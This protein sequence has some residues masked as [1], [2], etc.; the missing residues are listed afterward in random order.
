MSATK[1]SQQPSESHSS[2]DVSTSP[3]EV[4]K[5][6]LDDVSKLTD[7]LMEVDTAASEPPDDM[8]ALV[9]RLRVASRRADAAILAFG[10]LAKPS[11]RKRIRRRLRRL[12]TG[13]GALRAAQVHLQTLDDLRQN[14]PA[15]LADALDI[16]VLLCERDVQMEWRNLKACMAS[17]EMT[18]PRKA[19][20]QFVRSWK[21]RSAKAQEQPTWSSFLGNGLAPAMEVVRELV[22][23]TPSS[24]DDLHALR[25]GGKKL[26]YALEIFGPCL[27]EAQV[28][29]LAT[30]LKD[31]QVR[32]GS[33]NDLA[34]LAE[35][36]GEYAQTGRKQSLQM[37]S[38]RRRD[39]QTGNGETTD[40]RLP[41]RLEA[42]QSWINQRLR[43][44]VEEFTAAWPSASQS[45]LDAFAVL[46]ERIQVPDDDQHQATVPS[47]GALS[48]SSDAPD[49]V[50]SN[51]MMEVNAQVAGR[52]RTWGPAALRSVAQS[53]QDPQCDRLA[54]LDIGTNSIRL[55]IA[56]VRPDGSYRVLDD[57]KDTTRLGSGLVT[58]G[59]LSPAA[60]D[61]AIE[62]V[63]RMNAI[64]QGYG[65]K[66]LR[67]VGTCAVREAENSKEFVKRMK[68]EAG[69]ELEVISAEAEAR[70]AHLSVSTAFDLNA[71][72]AAVVDIGGGSTEIVLSSRGVIEH[73]YS[74]MLGAVGLTEEHKLATDDGDGIPEKRFRQMR[75]QVRDA[76]KRLIGKPPLAPQTVFGTGGTFTA[77]ASVALCR[78]RPVD[79]DP[80]ALNV[81]GYD[82][83]RPT[84]KHLLHWLRG[85]SS[86][87]RASVNG[88]SPERAEIIVAGA[89]IV[90]AVLG[91]LGSNAVRVHDRGIRD[92][93]MLQMIKEHGPARSPGSPAPE[94]IDP[95]RSFAR[96]CNYEVAHSEHVTMLALEVFDQLAEAQGAAW[97]TPTARRLLEAASVLHDVGYYINYAKH[98]KHSYH[99]ILHSELAGFT[100][101]EIAI[102]A[103]VARYHRRS[104][105]K[106]SHA[107]FSTLAK[108]DQALVRRLAGILRIVD[109]LDRAHGQNV[110]R[111][112]VAVRGAEVRFTA[113]AKFEPA[114]DIW[115]AQRKSKL[116]EST[117]DRKVR[118]NWVRVLSEQSNRVTSMEEHALAG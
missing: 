94:A 1:A 33:V 39:N 20:K 9:H 82:L 29:P 12:R 35:R 80:G 26:R 77:L 55:V 57:E 41:A 108:K 51:R 52:D 67:A 7:R 31:L 47:N 28:E 44:A 19:I 11:R 99:L 25:I 36:L 101:R 71:I 112:D 40:D 65:V 63:K 37:I 102:I 107:N 98:H 43:A 105:P 95:V 10:S 56:E 76:L 113:H 66:W 84:L 111:V 62:A 5:S 81:R 106:R 4:L 8:M 90:D 32:L 50:E 70:L 48:A 91:R 115:G 13:A 117:M 103:N 87:E 92:G 114:V 73:V 49:A 79:D 59:R 100:H 58:T 34:G 69:V 45:L 54:A 75:S 6:G 38:R 22:V 88:L 93:L 89:A 14:G 17:G 109:G 27:G 15:E 24:V 18:W 110:H 3:Q 74:L 21:R 42:L 68:R 118:F 78:N 23:R 16:A 97:M 64:A 30:G 46:Q 2:A 104:A 116:L 72:D 60:M 96:A 53:A 86:Q 83:T 61:Q 85:M